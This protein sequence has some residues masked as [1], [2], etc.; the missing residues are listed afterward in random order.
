MMIEYRGW[1]LQQVVENGRRFWCTRNPAEGSWAIRQEF[2]SLHDAQQY[3]DASLRST[4]Q[5]GEE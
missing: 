1:L 4:G 5:G 3:V 2:N